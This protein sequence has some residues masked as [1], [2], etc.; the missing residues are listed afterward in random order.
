MHWLAGADHSHHI[1]GRLPQDINTEISGV[2]INWMYKITGDLSDLTS[3]R[4]AKR[5]KSDNYNSKETTSSGQSGKRV[6]LSEK[7]QMEGIKKVITKE[8]TSSGKSGK[9]VNRKK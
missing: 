8:M 1:K 7:C 4:S 2:L 6:N 3:Q 9:R 5:K